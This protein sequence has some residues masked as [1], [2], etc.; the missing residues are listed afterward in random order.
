[1]SS[2]KW[3]HYSRFSLGY[4][5]EKEKEVVALIFIQYFF[6]L[7]FSVVLILIYLEHNLLPVTYRYH[8]L[9]VLGLISLL[10]I[11]LRWVGIAKFLTLTAPAVL[12]LILPP[13]AGLVDAEFYFWFPYVPIALSLI[14]HFILHPIRE[15][16]LLIAIILVYFL[17][18]LLI[19]NLL[20]LKDSHQGEMVE[21]VRQNRFYY[22]LIPVFIYSFVNISLG[23]LFRQNARYEEIMRTQQMDLAQAEKMASLGTLA[24]GIA[25]E[26]NNPLNFISG[27]LHALNTLK[28]EYLKTLPE[29]SSEQLKMLGQIEKIMDSSFEGVHRASEII[30][31]LQ[32]FASPSRKEK[33]VV[34]LEQL[35]YPVLLE[36]R[37]RL[38]AHTLLHEEIPTGLNI[39]CYEEPLQQ[40]IANV[41][42][43]AVDAIESKETKDQERIDLTARMDSKNR[44]PLVRITITN[45]GPSIPEEELHQVFDPFFTSKEVGEGTGLGMTISYMIISEHQG[46]IRIRNLEDGVQ[47]DI[48]LPLSVT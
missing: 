46:S 30:S 43:N 22:N 1:M 3:P 12:L 44:N 15:R 23:L 24:A 31:S 25:H 47:V 39:R 28:S 48:L 17:L 11:R 36:I 16:S 21:I 6:I 7:L 26:I 27:S 45:S 10:F 33:K 18:G 14:P 37:S 41:L 32:F 40:A 29:P 9:V 5:F 34:D 42:D 19:D 4:R 35:L 2:I 20:I 8:G 38:P 13:L